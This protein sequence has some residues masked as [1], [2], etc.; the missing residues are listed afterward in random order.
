MYWRKGSRS[1]SACYY[2]WWWLKL[3]VLMTKGN[4]ITK[5]SCW[6]WITKCGRKERESSDC[7]ALRHSIIQHVPREG[8]TWA[9]STQQQ[10]ETFPPPPLPDLPEEVT[11]G[12]GKISVLSHTLFY[13]PAYVLQWT[14][15]LGHM[16]Y[17]FR[18]HQSSQLLGGGW[19]TFYVHLELLFIDVHIHILVSIAQSHFLPYV[20]KLLTT[21]FAR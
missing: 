10:N 4:I 19:R 21:Y 17:C 11:S 15:K 20:V 6:W 16:S 18:P 2:R 8:A 13:I 12:I 14:C 5:K 9:P 7:Q 3:K 1:R